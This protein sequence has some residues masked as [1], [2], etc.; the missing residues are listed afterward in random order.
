MSIGDI[1]GLIAAIAFA[2]LA[3]VAIYPLIRLGRMLDQIATTVKEAGDHTLPILDESTTSV[4]E[5]NKTL[6]DVNQ[7]TDSARYT[8]RN[9]GA[10][11]DL[12]SSMLSKPVI[13]VASSFYAVKETL[14]GFMKHSNTTTQNSQLNEDGEKSTTPKAASKSA[15][16]DNPEQSPLSR[17]KHAKTSES[18]KPE[19][20]P[21]PTEEK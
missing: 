9:V 14:N 10:L 16:R 4:R 7:I 11:T 18:E 17:A 5:L 2:I 1:A 6:S 12:Y 3:G 19:T 13:K 21:T 20:K 15:K 8:A